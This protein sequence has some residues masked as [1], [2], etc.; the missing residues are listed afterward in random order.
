M[1][2][3]KKGVPLKCFGNCICFTG[4][5]FCLMGIFRLNLDRIATSN[6]SPT[7]KTKEEI[8]SRIV[9]GAVTRISQ[10]P[11]QLSVE[12]YDRHICGANIITSNWALSAAHCFPDMFPIPAIRIRSGT[13][14]ATYY[15]RVHRIEEI[16]IHNN[17]HA[18]SDGTPVNDI[19]LVKLRESFF[20]SHF[21]KRIDMF[22]ENQSLSIGAVGVIS[23]WGHVSETKQN[24]ALNLHVA[25]VPII[26]RRECLQSYPNLPLGQICA[27][28]PKGNIDS[29]SGD[30]G[31]PLVINRKLAGVVSWG[32]GCGRPGYPGVYSD[33]T[34]YRRWIREIT[35]V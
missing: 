16:I 14:K 15:G 6:Y 19:A 1:N 13:S 8:Q 22:N 23:G 11:Y 17:Y 30:S 32:V 26:S 35:G 33:V 28:Y 10:V 4:D 9:G 5:K 12:L 29:C 34:F 24:Y 27:G 25:R 7:S 31:G 3:I 18:K 2:A 21:V 20:Y